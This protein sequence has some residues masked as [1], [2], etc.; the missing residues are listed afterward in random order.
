MAA[1]KRMAAMAMMAGLLTGPVAVPSP[2]RRPGRARRGFYPWQV[3]TD[4]LGRRRQ[5]TRGSS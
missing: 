5:V 3:F 1:I 4:W 2:A